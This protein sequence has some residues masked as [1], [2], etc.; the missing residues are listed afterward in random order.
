MH[1]SLHHEANS[2]GIKVL[3]VEPGAFRTPF[4]TRL[5]FPRHLANGKGFGDSYAGTPLDMMIGLSRG[6]KDIPPAVRGD[7]DK[8]AKEIVNAV[9]D[10]HDYLRMI[11]GTDC[12]VAMEDKIAS[13][14]SDL[15]ATRTIA[16]SVDVD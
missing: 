14:K 9:V 8:A 12:I 2:L 13:F 15:E 5:M 16:T 6:L 3:I 7:P 4:S 10:G 11:L 1:E